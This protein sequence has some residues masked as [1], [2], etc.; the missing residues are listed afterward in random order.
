M[1]KIIADTLA[2]LPEKV[3]KKYNIP[4]IS[5]NINFGND[6]YRENIDLQIDEF[7]KKLRASTDLPTTA[8][9]YPADYIKLFEEL[10]PLNE[11]I[12]IISP[13]AKMSGTFAS[14]SL[15]RKEFPASDIRV[16]DT[17]IIASPLGTIVEQACIWAEQGLSAD[18]IEENVL[19]LSSRNKTY[20]YVDT[21]DY[22]A[23]GGRI[24]GAKALM[25]SMLQ[26][27]PILCIENG[28][29]DQY[30]SIR[31]RKKALQRFKEI[32]HTQCPK[33]QESLITLMHADVEEEA[34]E[35]KHELEKELGIDDIYL[36][37]VPPAV[38]THAGPGVFA[39]GF[40]VD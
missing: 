5:Q 38:V 25:G 32:I 33:A 28:Q 1:V 7:Y 40:F 18:E 37:N 30:E 3:I 11:A 36:T 10:V 20:F 21:L 15:A 6:S 29:I 34:M 4:V 39:V 13:T 9:P 14:A 35:I 24:G 16:I 8:A 17:N 19:E 2:C 26:V 22:L 12:L 23:R 27:K 31:T